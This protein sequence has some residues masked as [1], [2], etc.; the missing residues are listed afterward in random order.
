MLGYPPFSSLVR[1]EFRSPEPGQAEAET[2]RLASQVRVWLEQEDRR[3]T[4]IIGPAP[5]Y[6][7]R[8]AGSYRWQIVL[9]GPDPASLLRGRKLGSRWQ[10]EVNPSSLL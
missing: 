3:A 7:S 9:R 10:V 4:E 5:C 6:F 8:I 1:L 2:Q